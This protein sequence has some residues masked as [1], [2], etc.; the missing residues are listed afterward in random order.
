MREYLK[1]ASLSLR[2]GSPDQLREL[3]VA[4]LVSGEQGWVKDSRDLM[5]ALAPYHHCAR[6]LG[7]DV[8]AVFGAAA[9][10]GPDSIEAVVIAFG[11][12]DDVTPEAFGFEVA[13]GAE[14]RFYRYVPP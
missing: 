9:H 8:R 4:E 7:L 12:R 13:H 14:G 1:A 11:E 6:E 10:D 2:S 3:L 5:M